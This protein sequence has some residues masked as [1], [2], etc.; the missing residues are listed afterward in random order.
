[1][2]RILLGVGRSQQIGGGVEP[3]ASRD[4]CENDLGCPVHRYPP[5]AVRR[6][7]PKSIILVLSQLNK[8]PLEN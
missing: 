5:F 1:M 2:Q 7:W 6:R 8:K 3:K 4:Q